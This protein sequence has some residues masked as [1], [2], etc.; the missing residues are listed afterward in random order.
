[1]AYRTVRHN[2][3]SIVSAA[4]AAERLSSGRGFDAGRLKLHDSRRTH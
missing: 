3:V 2:L 4:P 1:M